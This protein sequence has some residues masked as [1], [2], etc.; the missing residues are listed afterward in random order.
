MSAKKKTIKENQAK[1]S[2][3]DIIR[4]TDDDKNL[5]DLVS[6]HNSDGINSDDDN[7]IIIMIML[8]MMM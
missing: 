8:I 1:S 5:A 2:N 7:M 4:H 6:D 3:E